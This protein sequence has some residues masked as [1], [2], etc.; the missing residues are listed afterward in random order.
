MFWAGE[1]GGTAIADV[2]FGDYNP[3]GRLPYTV[4]ASERGLPPM[5]EYDISKGFTYMYMIDKPLYAFGRGLSYTNFAYS[6]LRISSPRIGSDGRVQ[7]HVDVKNTGDR[8]GDEVVQLYVHN[9]DQGAVQPREQLQGF[10]RVSLNPGESKTVDFTLPVE[11]LSFW[12]T[13][14]HA[15][16]IHPGTFDVMV[17]SASDDIRQKGSFEVSNAGEWP[18]TD[19]TTRLADGD[20]SRA[21]Q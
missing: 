7:I 14:K 15:Y 16:V 3:S 4:Y 21:A 17:G 5:T 9:N 12:D 20:Y 2:L 8:A 19:L 18:P 6:N 1:E 10:E 11:Q 13:S